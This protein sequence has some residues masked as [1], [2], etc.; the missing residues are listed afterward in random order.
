M[1]PSTQLICPASAVSLATCS[2][3]CAAASRLLLV[4]KLVSLRFAWLFLHYAEANLQHILTFPVTLLTRVMLLTHINTSE[5]FFSQ[6]LLEET[7]L[8]QYKDKVLLTKAQV[9]AN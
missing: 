4:P 6:P 5:I 8:S 7:V 2:N 3:L 1:K 9:K